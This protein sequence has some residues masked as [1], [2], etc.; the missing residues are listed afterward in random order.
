MV[1]SGL[2]ELNLETKGPTVVFTVTSITLAALSRTRL[3]AL[4]QGLR[5][6]KNAIH[7]TATVFKKDFRL[8][9]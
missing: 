3:L 6:E 1:R 8:I 5:D 7:S 9:R 4:T 2:N